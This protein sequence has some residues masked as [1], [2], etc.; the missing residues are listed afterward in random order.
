[1]NPLDYLHLQLRLEGKQVI[2]ANLLR[3]V[4]IVPGEELPLMILAQLAQERVAAFY[5][6]SLTSEIRTRLNGQ[7]GSMEFPKVDSILRFLQS[8]GYTLQVGHYK[9]YVFPADY[10][11]LTFEEVK[12][13][14][15]RHPKIQAFGFDQFAEEVYA[16][17]QAGKIISACVSARENDFCGEAWVYTDDPYR[18]QGFAQ[19]VV[20]IW[21]RNL[22]SANKIPFY[23]HT[24]ENTASANLAKRL[25]LMLVFEE[26][27][28]SRL[29]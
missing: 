3:Q 29:N 9:T 18:R 16:M 23:S 20:G 14:S 22:I 1:M 8:L 6:E 13:F 27:V 2:D 4:E 28:I 12:Q 19:K 5:D 24:I 11:R 17:E 10:H 25:G 7:I 26:I 15:K 21:A